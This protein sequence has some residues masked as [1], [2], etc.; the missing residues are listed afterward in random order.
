MA[1]AIHRPSPFGGAN[2]TYFNIGEVHEN[3]LNG[4]ATVVLHGFLDRAARLNGAG[5]IPE[6][7]FLDASVWTPDAS[8]QEIYGILKTLPSY[9][10]A[11]D[12]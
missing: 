10:D 9:S 12:V 1:L 3:R 6:S 7:V 11:L 8:I 4:C 2:F 5:Y